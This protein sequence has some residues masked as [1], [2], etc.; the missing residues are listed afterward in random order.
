V[1]RAG[2][3]GTNTTM[4]RKLRSDSAQGT[5]EYLLATG[6]FVVALITALFGF[7]VIVEQVVEQVC[8]S[9]DTI[10]PVAVGECIF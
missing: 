9:V 8:P 4:R 6:I 3:S 2:H 1:R 5:F 10:D 7:N